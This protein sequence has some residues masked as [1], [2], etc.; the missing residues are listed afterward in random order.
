MAV[1]YSDDHCQVTSQSKIHVGLVNNILVTVVVVVVGLFHLISDFDDIGWF[2]FKWFSF[3]ICLK[4]QLLLNSGERIF[5]EIGINIIFKQINFSFEKFIKCMSEIEETISCCYVLSVANA[6]NQN[7][8]L[9][10]AL[11][12]F[13]GLI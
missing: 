2:K 9:P 10:G 8:A 6:A 1:L 13:L 7:K 5:F 12:T 3:S 4:I 11:N